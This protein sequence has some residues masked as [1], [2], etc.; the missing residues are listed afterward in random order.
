MVGGNARSSPRGR[1]IELSKRTGITVLLLLET[2]AKI[3]SCGRN[4]LL[5]RFAICTDPAVASDV[6]RETLAAMARRQLR[7]SGLNYRRIDTRAIK[8]R[9]T[10][11]YDPEPGRP[12]K[13]QPLH[14]ERKCVLASG[15][16]KLDIPTVPEWLQ[17]LAY[18]Q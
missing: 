9:K 13:L 11:R 12:V 2:K 10:K 14:N 4:R 3:F 7:A 6:H 1:K 8:Y 16:G 18:F 5:D 17:E 15:I